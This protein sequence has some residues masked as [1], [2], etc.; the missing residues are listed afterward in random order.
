MEIRD[1][2]E[3]DADALSRLADG[4]IDVLRNLVHDRTVRVALEDG[5]VVAFV[6][7]DARPGIVYVT[8][9]DGD[10]DACERLLDEPMRFARREG[11]DVE[12]LVPEDD[13]DVRSVVAEAG[14]DQTGNGPRFADVHTLRYRYSP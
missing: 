14:F 9:L 1:A 12:L 13:D 4:P 8:Q 7:F 6:S 11:M 3:A 10:A 2:V 5:E